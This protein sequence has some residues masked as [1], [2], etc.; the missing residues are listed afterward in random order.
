M[1]KA[2]SYAWSF[3]FAISPLSFFWFSTIVARK[4]CTS[5]PLFFGFSRTRL[6]ASTCWLSGAGDVAR[7]RAM[8]EMSEVGGR[9]C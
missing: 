6:R 5:T 4:C 3:R 8:V 7:R 2:L 1:F 9:S